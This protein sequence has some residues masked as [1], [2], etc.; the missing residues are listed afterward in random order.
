LKN[1]IIIKYQERKEYKQIRGNDKVCCNT[2]DFRML[3]KYGCNIKPYKKK[4]KM[5]KKY[6]FRKQNFQK[7]KKIYNQNPYKKMY[8]RRKCIN[9]QKRKINVH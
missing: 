7:Y 3:Q 4:Y 5:F 8:F 1:W 2:R 6:K 9:H